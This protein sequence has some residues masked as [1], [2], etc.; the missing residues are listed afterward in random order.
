VPDAK[1]FDMPM[2]FGLELMT[3]VGSNFSNAEREYFD[4]VV[5]KPDRVCLSV[6]LVNLERPNSRCIINCCV[7]ETTDFFAIFS[8][9]GQELNV[10]L[11]MVPPSRGLKCKPL[12]GSGKPVSDSAWCAVSA[13]ACLWANG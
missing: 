1:V 4:D 5:N 9:E 10:D 12:P 8:F 13:F 2:E 6:F 3:V 11:Y 7:L